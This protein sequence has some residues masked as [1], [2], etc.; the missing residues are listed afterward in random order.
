MAAETGKNSN[1]KTDSH[2][3]I[4]SGGANSSR[5]CPLR[6][7]TARCHQASGYLTWGLPETTETLRIVARFKALTAI[8]M[9]ALTTKY[10]N[11][12]PAFTLCRQSSTNGRSFTGST[13]QRIVP[14]GGEPT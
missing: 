14:H 8:G 6:S 9:V 13:P 1:Y 4:P 10:T 2:N 12:G 7:A 11:L 3:T 5:T